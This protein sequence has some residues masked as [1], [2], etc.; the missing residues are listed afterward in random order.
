[1]TRVWEARFDQHATPYGKVFQTVELENAKVGQPPVAVHFADPLAIW[2]VLAVEVPSLWDVLVGMAAATVWEWV[3]YSD[4]ATA[5]NLLQFD[6][7]KAMEMIYVPFRQFG[8]RLHFVDSWACICC[9]RN[10]T[11]KHVRGGLATVVRVLLEKCQRAS[12]QLMIQGPVGQAAL[13]VRA[14]MGYFISDEAAQQ[15]VMCFKGARTFF[16]HL[17]TSNPPMYLH[18]RDHVSDV[19]IYNIDNARQRRM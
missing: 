14:V 3:F 4:G 6:P 17:R 13:Y 16:K 7:A 15:H 19:Y 8:S 5:G 2:S 18:S 12:A 1:M 9:I 10:Q 11:L